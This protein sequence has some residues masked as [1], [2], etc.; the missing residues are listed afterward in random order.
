M[1]DTHCPNCS[2]PLE[3]NVLSMSHTCPRCRRE[4]ADNFVRDAPAGM[5]DAPSR[6]EA[7]IAVPPGGPTISID[8][9]NGEA[10]AACAYGW[11][12]AFAS[13]PVMYA[14]A[15]RTAA[16]A[17]RYVVKRGDEAV[18]MV[19]V[20]S[21]TSEGAAQA[22]ASRPTWIR[23]TAWRVDDMTGPVSPDLWFVVDTHAPTQ[24]PDAIDE[25]VAA[26]NAPAPAH[27]PMFPPAPPTDAEIVAAWDA[28]WRWKECDVSGPS[29]SQTPHTAAWSKSRLVSV[30]VSG[31]NTTRAQYDAARSRLLAARCAASD[32]Q[33]RRDAM[34]YGPIDDAD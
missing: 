2:I 16:P 9:G 19:A 28:V 34:V 25:I 17:P 8:T 3:R 24:A 7:T 23:P 33:R 1:S 20:G 15:S 18:G 12:L 13:S 30:H 21:W 4:Y 22:H 11:D 26:H 14:L 27:H 29:Q 31:A 10:V 5:F 32:E 6:L